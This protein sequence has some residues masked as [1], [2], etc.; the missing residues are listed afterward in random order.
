M[1]AALSSAFFVA[2]RFGDI[3]FIFS[4]PYNYLPFYISLGKVTAG[5]H[6]LPESEA[7]DLRHPSL[8]LGLV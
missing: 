1:L 8:S 3:I 2:P 7:S 4:G 6:R 5:D